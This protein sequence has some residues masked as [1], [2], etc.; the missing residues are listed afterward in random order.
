MQ[1]YQEGLRSTFSRNGTPQP[2][3]GY[4][5]DYWQLLK[6]RVM[7]LV[8]FTGFA[9]MIMAPGQI[10]PWIGLV[11][12]LCIAVC[13][14][15]SGAI[16]MG[17]EAD[18]DA[19]MERTR[20]RPTVIGFVTPNDAVVFGLWLAIGS[21]LMMTVVVNAVAGALLLASSVIYVGIY[22]VL[23]KRR[24]PYNIVIGGAAGAIP[25][26]IGWAA[27]TA[28]ISWTAFWLFL[29]IFM[30]TPPHFWAL[31][32][33]K[34]D[35]YSRAKVP[36]L[37]VVSTEEKTKLQILVYALTLFPITYALILSTSLHPVASLIL[38]TLNG[39]F[40]WEALR[41]YKDLGFRRANRVFGQSIVYL[42]VFFLTLIFNAAL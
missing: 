36:M 22:T 37:S 31:A 21:T 18:I 17:L 29:L 20:Q 2:T 3:R 25:P 28:D 34:K 14:G 1:L 32:L 11:A 16:N 6:P 35:E 39:V 12:M 15:A 24:T 13:A 33:V 23:L 5:Q 41:L 7:S 9:G 8:V 30:W 10:H 19:L 27:V 40:T 42:F 4:A 38:L 26:M